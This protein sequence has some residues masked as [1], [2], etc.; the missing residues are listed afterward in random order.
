MHNNGNQDETCQHHCALYRVGP[1]HAAQATQGGVDQHDD[2]QQDHSPDPIHLPTA[3]PLH[4]VPHD[5]ELGEHVVHQHDHQADHHQRTQ[6]P[7]GESERNVIAGGNEL[8]F[9][10]ESI[11]L[12]R[13]QQVACHHGDHAVQDAEPGKSG[14]IGLSRETKQRIAAVLGG[15]QGQ[16]QHPQA[17]AAAA[18]VVVR[19]AVVPSPAAG[20]PTHR[21]YRGQIHRNETEAPGRQGQTLHAQSRSS[22]GQAPRAPQTTSPANNHDAARETQT[23]LGTS[24]PSN[25]LSLGQ[26]QGTPM[27]ST[28]ATSSNQ[29][30][31]FTDCRGIETG[32]PEDAP[33]GALVGLV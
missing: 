21:Q 24:Q 30:P 7:G 26:Y 27:N 5:L 28:S 23:Q 20:E 18:Q 14:P 12:R 6:C 17:H 31:R 11:K 29:I 1:R 25:A 8:L 9:P 3:Q 16:H 19:Q 13:E 10:G 32:A 2:S 4:H 33:R 15:K 22:S